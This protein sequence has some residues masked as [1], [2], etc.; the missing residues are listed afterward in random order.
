MRGAQWMSRF[1]NLIAKR[2]RFDGLALLIVAG[3]AL[4]AFGAQSGLGV[5]GQGLDPVWAAA[6]SRGTLRVAVDLGFYPFTWMEAGRPAGY[7]I[8]LAHA[9]ARKLGLEVEF[10]PTGLDSI[11]DDLAAR[12]ADAAI[13]A[14]PYA[15]EQGWRA[16]FSEFYFNAGQVLVVRKGSAIAAEADLGGTTIGVALGS[17]ADTYAR[18]RL[19]EGLQFELRSDFDT[20]DEVLAALGR[21]E[22]D[23]AIVDNTAALIG[24]TRAPELRIATALTLEPYVIAVAPEAYQLHTAINQALADLR[25]EGFFED[26]GAKWFR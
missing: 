18:R 3:Y 25:A 4:L 2:R 14:L 8:D 22:L 17:D 26:V 21:G 20:P 23:A 9:V 5:A 11:F 16:R 6:Q 1:R 15:P 12:R 10:V 13:S 24:M 19:A 7:D